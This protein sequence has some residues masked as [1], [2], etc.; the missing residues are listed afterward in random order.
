MPVPVL[1]TLHTPSHFL[2][3]AI[4]QING[5]VVAI[6]LIRKLTLES[7]NDFENGPTI[8]WQSRDSNSVCYQTIRSYLQHHP[9]SQN[10]KADT[11]EVLTMGRDSAMSFTYKVP[12]N[13]NDDLGDRY[14]HY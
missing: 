10:T 7:R 4:L 9:A 13:P 3:T 8:K 11:Y 12:S 2:P 6:A 5:I 14:T 1:S